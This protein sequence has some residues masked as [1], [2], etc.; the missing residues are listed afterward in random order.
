M[1]HYCEDGVMR[2]LYSWKNPEDTAGGLLLPHEKHEA[3]TDNC[4]KFGA[5]TSSVR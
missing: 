4:I 1:G 2:S 3:G 5:I